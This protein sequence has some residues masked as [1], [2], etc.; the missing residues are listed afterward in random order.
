[1]NLRGILEASLQASKEP[2]GLSAR[3]PTQE[4]C[5]YWDVAAVAID[6]AC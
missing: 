3:V 1:M 4:S 2:H 6:V 5:R